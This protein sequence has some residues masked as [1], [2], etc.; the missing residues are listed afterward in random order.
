MNPYFSIIIPTYNA[1]ITLP[2]TLDSVLN[3]DFLDYE[4]IV[5]DDA[6]RDETK[7]VLRTY[8]TKFKKFTLIEQETNGGVAAARN[9]GFAKAVGRYIALL[10]SDDLW[11]KDKLSTQYALIEKSGCDIC[12]TSYDFIDLNGDSIQ[13]PYLVQDPIDYNVLLKENK[14][15]CSTVAVRAALLN[16]NSM[17]GCFAH[18]DYALWLRLLRE[19]AVVRICNQVLVHYRILN[20]GRSH[21]KF[22]AAINRFKIYIEQEKMGVIKASRYFVLYAL[23]GIRKYN[24]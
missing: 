14:I 6:S 24:A 13:K 7:E 2:E 8:R 1:A 11:T 18:E 15:G 16:E 21:N 23:A 19:G 17:N 5:I 12:C 3:Q 20:T 10:D 9:K 22:K 4:V